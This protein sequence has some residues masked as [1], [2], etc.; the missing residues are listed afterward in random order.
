M[1]TTTTPTQLNSDIGGNNNFYPWNWQGKQYQV[2]YETIGKGN[3][4]LLLPALSTVSSRTEMNGI[5]KILATNYQVTVIDWLGFGD[6]QCPRVDYS[7]QLFQ[8]LLEDF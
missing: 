6:S 3:P 5:A 8:Q 2:V 7:P 1:T 4:I